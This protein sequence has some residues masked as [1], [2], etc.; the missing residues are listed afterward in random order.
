MSINL[1]CCTS[2]ME[3]GGSERQ[4]LQ[5]LAKIDRSKIAPHLY[6]T[7]R[8]GPLLDQIPTDVV[9]DSFAER[10]ASKLALVPGLLFGMQ[11]RKLRQVVEKRSIQVTYD[12]L[13]HTV[14]LGAAALRRRQVARVI[15]VVS[16]P[17]RDFGQSRQRWM[18]IKRKLLSW[19]Y[20]TAQVLLAV[21]EESAQDA[22]NFYDIPLSRW[23]IVPS[24][25]DVEKVQQLA[26]ENPI[27]A[28][29]TR[30][31]I[32]IAMVGR[33]SEEKNH[34]LILAVLALAKQSSDPRLRSGHLHV[35]GD[36]PLKS[37]LVKIA[38]EL[39]LEDQVT[40]YGV[41]SNPHSIVS[42]CDCLCLPSTYEGFPNV[43]MEAMVCKTP[44][45]AS[46][47]AGG[48]QQLV[49]QQERGILLNP[50]DATAWLNELEKLAR[51][52]DSARIV[53]AK[54]RE[55]VVQNHDLPRWVSEM[56]SIFQE[57]ADC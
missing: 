21:S 51:N 43:V 24:P 41:Q 28:F 29:R 37:A 56:E 9:V 48:L 26:M 57:A 47:Q 49:G 54:A 53:A 33:L 2:S 32:N 46:N 27:D 52:L 18:T 22:S 8:T 10:D 45:I 44:V 14:M 55:F 7:Y 5:L 3:S 30:P 34:K 16:P 6:L 23:K 40:F 42:R 13:Y 25:V 36:G 20:R 38:K 31:G 50:S 39:Q 1:L 19:S 12:R 17:S 4:M 11:L 35:V 15:T